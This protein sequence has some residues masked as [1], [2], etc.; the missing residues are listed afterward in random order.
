MGSMTSGGL[1]GWSRSS[2]RWSGGVNCRGGHLR[3]VAR[4]AATD[5]F[6]S[7]P[8]RWRL[9][10]GVPVDNSPQD[11]CNRG[12]CTRPALIELSAMPTIPQRISSAF[13][14][15][16]GRYG[17]ITRMSRDRER[18]RQSL[19]R[20]AEQVIGAVDGSAAR[21]RVAEL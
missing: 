3:P 1:A 11:V 5:L 21:A 10:K 13:A 14:V 17:D 6:A 16:C 2:S 18:S 19:Y 8:S 7:A 20:E 12:G 9:L 4:I 15:Q